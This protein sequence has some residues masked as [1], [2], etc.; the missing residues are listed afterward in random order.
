MMCPLCLIS[1]EVGE[2]HSGVSNIRGGSSDILCRMSSLGGYMEAGWG[3]VGRGLLAERS[4]VVVEE[5]TDGEMEKERLDLKH[6][7][8]AE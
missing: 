1:E 7:Q 6:T 2:E 8:K 4:T 3:K 5:D